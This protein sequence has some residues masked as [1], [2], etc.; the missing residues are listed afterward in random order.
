[1]LIYEKT[2]KNS[3]RFLIHDE[4]DKLLNGDADK[5]VST[6]ETEPDA[7][8]EAPEVAVSV[9]GEV[10][11]KDLRAAFPDVWSEQEERWFG[12]E[13]ASWGEG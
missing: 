1:M 3:P 2:V 6:G 4:L 7:V 9:R 8:P 13:M 11:L 5:Q 12:G 10:Y